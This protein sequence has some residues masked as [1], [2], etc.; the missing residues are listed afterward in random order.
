MSYF[1]NLF[2]DQFINAI[3]Y[4]LL[5][6]LWQAPVIALIMFVALKKSDSNK[7]TLRYNLALASLLLVF[8]S[9][10][11]TFMFYFLRGMGVNP[12]SISSTVQTCASPGTMQAIVSSTLPE[13]YNVSYLLENNVERI[14]FSWLVGVVLF[15]LRILIGQ[16]HLNSIKSSLNYGISEDYQNAVNKIS[17]KL[18]IKKIIRI[19]SSQKIEVP[20]MMGHL[21]PIIVL[22]IA[23]INHLSLEETET[24]LAHEIGHIMRHDFL[25]NII[26]LMIEA[27]LFFNPAVWWICSTIRSEREN[28]CDDLSMYLY[29]N[30]FSYART[31]IKL[32][33]IQGLSQPILALQLFN[34]KNHFLNRIKRVLNQP[35]N[36]SYT[37]ERGIATMLLF[38]SLIT[39]S[40]ATNYIKNDNWIILDRLE[41]KPIQFLS[42][43]PE[44]FSIDEKSKSNSP[45][46][47]KIEVRIK[48][49]E[50]ATIDMIGD[51]PKEESHHKI[52]L[53]DWSD[54]YSTIAP[55]THTVKKLS[56]TKKLNDE[57]CA[58]TQSAKQIHFMAFID[59]D[60][61]YR[62]VIDTIDE[63]EL[64]LHAEQMSSE[65]ERMEAK[66]NQKMEE[67]ERKMDKARMKWEEKHAQDIEA[68][69]KKMKQFGTE[70][71]KKFDNDEWE[72]AM[73][74]LTEKL[75]KEYDN[76]WSQ[77]MESFGDELSSSISESIDKDWIEGIAEISADFGTELASLV[78]VNLFQDHLFLDEN[79]DHFHFEFDGRDSHNL[80]G[81]LKKSLLNHLIKDGLWGDGKNKFMINKDFVR[82]NGKTYEGDLYEKYK[83][84]VE[85][86]LDEPI[87]ANTSVEFRMTGKDPK[88]S[89]NTT[90]S[91]SVDN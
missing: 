58:T 67:L 6:S 89:K 53:A 21:R 85:D 39:L 36:I 77:K 25:Q 75:S 61:S 65:S 47:K 55:L 62:I 32:Q 5:H 19:A 73:E 24:I 54:N 10:L 12:T 63:D 50:I 72:I 29:P 74:E 59:E 37:R 38:I 76:E 18:G 60:D 45:S 46:V 33:D 49:Q 35:H 30:R 2:S 44:L 1:N 20:M 40:S 42:V 88:S 87:D 4:T 34:S 26:I 80:N 27:L 86:H 66:F 15:S 48:E 78:T 52:D 64:R 31:L 14:T 41:H 82:I 83:N 8:G 3:S 91:I 70:F 7:S 23:A 69:E 81:D 17:N 22:P 43:L 68:F 71:S 57:D 11:F 56:S 79:E 16:W 84:I 28:S 9:A 51:Y 90:L 13:S